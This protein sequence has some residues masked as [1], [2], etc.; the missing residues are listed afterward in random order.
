MQP[1]AA[2]SKPR[3]LTRSTI[4]ERRFEHSRSANRAAPEPISVLRSRAR[5]LRRRAAV[6]EP[7]R[8][9]EGLRAD[10]AD[11]RRRVRL[12]RRQHI[13]SDQLHL[14]R[15]VDRSVRLRARSTRHLGRLSCDGICERHGLCRRAPA[16]VGDRAVQ[17]DVAAGD[18]SRVRQHLAYR[19]RVDRGVLG[20]RLRQRLCPGAHE[21]RDAGAL[22][23]DAHDRLDDRRPGRRQHDFLSDRVRRYLGR[24]DA[25]RRHRFQL[26]F[27]GHGRCLAHD[28]RIGARLLAGRDP[29]DRDLAIVPGRR[30]VELCT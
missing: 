15:C 14:R 21:G 17:R 5:R 18:R 12:R 22:A 13:F 20:R 28:D 25:I 30:R 16:G 7:D 27:Q 11:R 26:V 8:H 23:L 3:K 19:R 2:Q 10:S 29:P 4:G 6:L 9:C 1:L 24:R